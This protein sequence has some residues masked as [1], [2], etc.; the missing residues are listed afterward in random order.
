MQSLIEG[1]GTKLQKE[2]G[3]KFNGHLIIQTS[4]M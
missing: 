1:I 4:L 3:W 2:I